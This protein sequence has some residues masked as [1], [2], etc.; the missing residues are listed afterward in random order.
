MVN[1]SI[2]TPCYNAERYIKE[3]IHSVINNNLI[4]EKKASLQ[5]IICDGGSSDNTLQCIQ[6][7]IDTTKNDNIEF[8]LI[9]EKDNGMYDALSK[10]LRKISGEICAY[11][12]AGDFYS[13][14]AFEIVAEI[15]EKYS[16]KWLTGFNITYNDKS[17]LVSC[18]LPFKH[19]NRLI[20]CGLHGKFIQLI[21]QESTFWHSSLCDAI[22][23]D[24]LSK[25]NYA[26]DYYVWLSLSNI[27]H[28]SIV[29][30][31]LGGFR[32][33]P[34][35]L[36]ENINEYYQEIDSITRR[37]T[38]LDYIYASYDLIGWQLPSKFKK[39]LNKNEIYRYNHQ[40]Q[41]FE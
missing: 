13:P 16:V 26:G 24:R 31:W 7:I 32:K 6:D 37:A 18:R 34:G 8:Q 4:Q 35:Q 39:L 28:L 14:Y 5:Y 41:L 20:Q 19:R 11:I 10:G 38:S 23:L 22:D 25:F 40:S 15:F 9:S 2:I 17:Q 29:E 33:H 1:L 30:A 27:S 12:N 36:S 21:Q 3:T